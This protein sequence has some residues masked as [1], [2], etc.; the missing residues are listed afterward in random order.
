MKDVKIIPKNSDFNIRVP[1]CQSFIMVILA[2]AFTYLIFTYFVFK[3]A[4]ANKTYTIEDNAL[5][6][7]FFLHWWSWHS[8]MPHICI[9]GTTFHFSLMLLNLALII[10]QRPFYTAL[11]VSSL[12]LPLQFKSLQYWTLSS[13]LFNSTENRR[14]VLIGFKTLYCR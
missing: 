5:K 6:E 12:L 8:Y 1:L 10:W 13:N 11:N 7:A 9:F 4:E 3:Q 14:A 2:C